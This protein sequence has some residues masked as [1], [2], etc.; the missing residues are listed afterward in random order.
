MFNLQPTSSFIYYICVYVCI[1]IY[2]FVYTHIQ[3][4]YSGFCIRESICFVKYKMLVCVFRDENTKFHLLHDIQ[5]QNGMALF[6]TLLYI[7]FL[8]TLVIKMKQYDTKITVTDT[9]VLL[10]DCKRYPSLKDILTMYIVVIYIHVSKNPY[11]I[12]IE[13]WLNHAGMY[14]PMFKCSML[15]LIWDPCSASPLFSVHVSYR[16]SQ[17]LVILRKHFKFP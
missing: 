14:F 15:P 4:E 10:C 9:H 1:Y 5:P 11:T 2:V 8:N 13:P 6:F 17:Q 7:C 12:E 16:W 3:N